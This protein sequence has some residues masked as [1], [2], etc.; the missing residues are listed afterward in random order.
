V[1]V[2][3]HNLN[4]QFVEDSKD[5]ALFTSGAYTYF[6]HYSDDWLMPDIVSNDFGKA[7]PL[8]EKNS[9]KLRSALKRDFLELWL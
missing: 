9:Q 8:S 6:Y 7:I 1:K 2:Y 5:G 4:W 3:F